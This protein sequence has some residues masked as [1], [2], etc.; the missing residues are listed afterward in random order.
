VVV[1]EEATVVSRDTTVAEVAPAKRSM[2]VAF[3]WRQQRMTSTIFS[4]NMA[5]WRKSSFAP[6]YPG[7]QPSHSLHSRALA[8]LRMLLLAGTIICSMAHACDVSS[9]KQNEEEVDIGVA[10]AAAAE[11]V[12]AVT[13]TEGAAAVVAAVVAVVV[14]A[15]AAAVAVA[16]PAVAAALVAAAAAAVAGRKRTA[17]AAAVVAV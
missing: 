12:V 14:P 9:A 7:L 15:V 16:V 11:G 5:G 2:S 1:V 10:V 13:P 8:M 6:T 3:R 17:E 4:T